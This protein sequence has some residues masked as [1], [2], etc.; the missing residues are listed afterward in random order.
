MNEYAMD[1]MVRSH[2][3][4]LM[5]EA[6]N[7]RLARLARAGREPGMGNRLPDFQPRL[8]GALGAIGLVLAA[9]GSGVL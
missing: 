2:Q 6:A 5:A 9:I 7:E 8:V 3:A 1:F 4:D